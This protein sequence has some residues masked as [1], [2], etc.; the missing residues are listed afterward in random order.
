ML[1]RYQGYSPLDGERGAHE[2]HPAWNQD[3]FACW[4]NGPCRESTLLAGER[5]GVTQILN[6]H[7]GTR[8]AST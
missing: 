1:G 3:G 4:V 2:L 7:H 6:R 8:E 5:F